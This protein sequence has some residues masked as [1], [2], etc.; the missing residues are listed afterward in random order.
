MR[1]VRVWHRKPLG[2]TRKVRTGIRSVR[3]E[4]KEREAPVKEPR[5]S[6]SAHRSDDNT[7]ESQRADRSAERSDP[8][9][10]SDSELSGLQGTSS[11][12]TCTDSN[13]G[14]T[15]TFGKTT[16]AIQTRTCGLWS[17][18]KLIRNAGRLGEKTVLRS[19][20]RTMR[21]PVRTAVGP[22]HAFGTRETP[23]FPG[24]VRRA[25]ALPGRGSASCR[26]ARCCRA[27][28]CRE[29]RCAGC[30]RRCRSRREADCAE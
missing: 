13:T 23:I 27:N 22:A 24:S 14:C 21:G 19:K 12:G 29:S 11:H 28:S 6:R 5:I 26:G 15:L 7:C 4:A 30:L 18:T 1:P 2:G 20:L 17:R 9:G 25:A 16:P 8:S 10:G 3:T